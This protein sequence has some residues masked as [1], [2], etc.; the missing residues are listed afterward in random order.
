MQF[1]SLLLTL[2][3][4]KQVKTLQKH[5]LPDH[6]G[7]NALLKHL[8]KYHPPE[9]RGGQEAGT[10]NTVEQEPDLKEVGLLCTNQ[11]I[12]HKDLIIASHVRL[13]NTL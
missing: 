2:L 10:Q 12:F 5:H 11:M 7:Q 4:F 9:L 3:Y 8:P 1:L 13:L 6:L